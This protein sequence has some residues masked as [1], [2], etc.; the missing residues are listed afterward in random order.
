M[1]SIYVGNIPKDFYDLE[2]FK[3]FKKHGFKVLKA[4]VHSKEDKNLG[5]VKRY[6][7]LQFVS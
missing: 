5:R 3:F 6:G 1:P 2:F 7:F 4:T